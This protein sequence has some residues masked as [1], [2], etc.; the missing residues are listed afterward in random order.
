MKLKFTVLKIFLLIPIIGLAQELNN[1]KFTSK[2]QYLINKSDSKVIDEQSYDI[3]FSIVDGEVIL[4]EYGRV[5]YYKILQTKQISEKEWNLILEEDQFLKINEKNNTL[6][7]GHDEVAENILYEID[8]K[9]ELDTEMKQEV[10][11]T[12][13]VNMSLRKANDLYSINAYQEAI[14][15]Y[16]EAAEKGS[17]KA[18]KKLAYMYIMGEGGSRN[19]QEALKWFKQAANLGDVNSIYNVGLIYDTGSGVEINYEQALKWYKKA[20]EKNHRLAK[21]NIGYL[22][23]A[24]NNYQDYTEAMKWFKEADSQKYPE[25]AYYIGMLYLDGLGVTENA[26]EAKKW[27]QRAANL[28]SSYGQGMLDE[29]E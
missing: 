13:G 1:V 11:S 27:F 3:N 19:Y 26:I 15:Y 6:L 22:Y 10:L 2:N 24:D 17:M 25:A 21:Y 5:D 16:K 8:R 4:E 20:A 23:Y 28:G 29:L 18:M 9:I 12:P 14:K 7:F